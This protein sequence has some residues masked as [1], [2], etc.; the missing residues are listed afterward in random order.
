[1]FNVFYF[2]L[3]LIYLLAVMRMSVWIEIINNS[4]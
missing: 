1:M 3:N 4:K 2:T